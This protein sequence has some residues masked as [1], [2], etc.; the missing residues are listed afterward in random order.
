MT[1]LLDAAKATLLTI[2]EVVR[3]SD[4]KHDA[5]DAAK[6]DIAALRAAIVE[7]EKADP[8]KK[9]AIDFLPHDDCL[10]FVQR[11]LESSAPQKDRDAAARM[12][13]DMR[14]SIYTAP[15]AP[16]GWQPASTNPQESDGEVL[17]RMPDGRPEIAWATYWHGAS[18]GFAKW[19][20][21]D[22][23]E[24]ETPVA[25]MKIPA[26]PKEPT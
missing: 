13:S 12:V 9:S 16:A 10:R 22:P 20:F 18:T 17:V 24:D 6:T 8:I 14:R 23:D 5:W 21:R 25:W 3:I 26:A 4:R 1:T 2:T 11:V 15:K 7:A 19:M